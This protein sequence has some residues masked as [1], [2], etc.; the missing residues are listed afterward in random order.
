[1]R[2]IV[3]YVEWV[4]STTSDFGSAISTWI[5]VIVGHVVSRSQSSVADV[6]TA[7]ERRKRKSCRKA[8]VQFIELA[9][10]V[11]LATERNTMFMCHCF[12]FFSRFLAFSHVFF[13]TFC[14][15]SR[16]S[17]FSRVF[18]FFSRV[19]KTQKGT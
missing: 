16:V 17:F 10:F 9:V 5:V 7:C 12:F 19:G 15:F 8:L 2:T 4:Y 18:F 6:G 11:K 13:L 14:F 3:A 1:M